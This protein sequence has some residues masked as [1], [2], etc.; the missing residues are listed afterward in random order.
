MVFVRVQSHCQELL[1][2][3]GTEQVYVGFSAEPR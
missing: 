3:A 2:D 1:G